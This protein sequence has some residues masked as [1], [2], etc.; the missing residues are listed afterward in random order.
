MQYRTGIYN[1][2][3]C[4]A[5]IDRKWFTSSFLPAGTV[6]SGSS[7]RPAEVCGKQ[8]SFNGTQ[9]AA[10]RAEVLICVGEG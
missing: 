8:G 10:V 5:F 7:E 9:Q 2:P 3:N 1:D 4:A 6:T